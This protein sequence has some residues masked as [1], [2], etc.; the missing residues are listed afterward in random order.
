[1]TTCRTTAPFYTMF[2]QFNFYSNP[3]SHLPSMAPGPAFGPGS[4][5]TLPMAAARPAEPSKPSEAVRQQLVA[6]G[7]QVQLAMK[8]AGWGL[9]YNWG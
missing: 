6:Q 9:A 7:Q 3:I 5:A 8:E 2:K 1:M 4:V